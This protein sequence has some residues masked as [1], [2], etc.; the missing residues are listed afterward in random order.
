[1]LD[2]PEIEQ[3]RKGTDREVRFLP[4]FRMDGDR[5]EPYVV[6]TAKAGRIQVFVNRKKIYR[7]LHNK[8]RIETALDLLLVDTINELLEKSA[9]REEQR[10][11]ELKEGGIGDGVQESRGAGGDAGDS[12]QGGASTGNG[13]GFV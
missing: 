12:G 6:I 10:E 5:V 9:E 7:T 13:G 4:S 11:K 2:T 8:N 3:A 1:M